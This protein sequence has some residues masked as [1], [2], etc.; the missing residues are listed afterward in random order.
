MGSQ[1]P[2]RLPCETTSSTPKYFF[3]G[4]FQH[5][6]APLLVD[7][8]VNIATVPNP[9]GSGPDVPPYERWTPDPSGPAGCEAHNC[10][11][12]P[13]SAPCSPWIGTG[14]VQY[15]LASPGPNTFNK[16]GQVDFANAHKRGFKNV[17]AMRSWHGCFGWTSENAACN[18]NFC[19]NGSGYESYRPNPDQTKY[20]TAT[21]DLHFSNTFFDGGSDTGDLTGARTVNITTGETTSTVISTQTTIENSGFGLN[22]V[23]FTNGGAGYHAD[24]DTGIHTINFASGGSTRLDNEFDFHCGTPIFRIDNASL[25]DLSGFIAAWNSGAYAGGNPD[26]NPFVPASGLPP[27]TDPNNYSASDTGTL[28]AGLTHYSTTISFTRTDT[29]LSWDFQ[30]QDDLDDPAG[31]HLNI[32]HHYGTITLSTTNTSAQV[33][34]D[35]KSLL[36]NWPLN[37]DALYP[38]RTDTKVSVAP[39]VTRLELQNAAPLGFNPYTV[40]DMTSP[41]NDCSGNVPFSVGWTPTYNQRAWFDPNIYQWKYPTGHNAADSAASALVKMFDG[42]VQGAPHAAGFQNFFA[43]SFIDYT[44]C[45]FVNPDDGAQSWDLYQLG[46]GMNASQFNARSGAQIPLNATQWTNFSQARKST[47]T[48]RSC[49]TPM[50]G[51]NGY[52]QDC[53]PSNDSVFLADNGGLFA[54]K[55]AVILDIW[56]SQNFARPAVHR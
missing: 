6:L 31:V 50:K 19:P 11:T 53:P 49:S 2:F 15:N 55:A 7:K 54:C 25:G 39:L 9:A 56:N 35:I 13:G 45:C 44:A 1:I 28:N 40:D 27:I 22:T 46:W 32:W 12:D 33:Y 29:T 48:A 38:W 34:T 24:P 26:I 14:D 36:A 3:G 43:Y 42:S 41:I 16:S 10:D 4:P 20:T 30:V 5:N 18:T 37:D 52:A 21:Y 17:H 23:F 47:R 51:A 8:F